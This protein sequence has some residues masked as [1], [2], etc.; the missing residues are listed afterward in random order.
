MSQIREEEASDSE[1]TSL[2]NS[3]TKRIYEEDSSD[4]DCQSI[5]DRE[6]EA[7]DSE[8]TSLY[9]SATKRIPVYEEDSSDDD[10]QSIFDNVDWQR[11]YKEY[12][13][14]TAKRIPTRLKR[15]FTRDQSNRG[16]RIKRLKMLIQEKKDII[17]NYI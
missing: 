1:A 4:D 7:S 16:V 3:A 6:E 15:R 13:I 12:E 2:Y 14:Y 9:N 11:A 5:F 17:S 8:A 10:C